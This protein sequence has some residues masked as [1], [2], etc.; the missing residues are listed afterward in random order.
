MR[1]FICLEM[2]LMGQSHFTFLISEDAQITPALEYLDNKT[3]S[4]KEKRVGIEKT[5]ALRKQATEIWCTI[6]H[7]DL[8]QTL[9]ILNHRYVSAVIL[10]IKSLDLLTTCWCQ[11]FKVRFFRLEF[12]FCTRLLRGRALNLGT[13]ASSSASISSLL[14]TLPW[15]GRA[16]LSCSRMVQIH[17]EGGV[18]ERKTQD[19]G[20]KG[21]C[22]ERVSTHTLWVEHGLQYEGEEGTPPWDH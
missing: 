1:T 10:S 22:H 17:L 8:Y 3:G 20:D 15:C 13:F 2:E 11:E 14:F 19:V 9:Y 16:I 21:C 5:W 12:R 18:I 6:G 4:Q 7:S